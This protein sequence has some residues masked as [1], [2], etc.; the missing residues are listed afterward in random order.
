[1]KDFWKTTS[2]HRYL[3]SHLSMF[4]ELPEL[5]STRELSPK[6]PEINEVRPGKKEMQ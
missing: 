1:M 2:I 6:D 3:V 5:I 4:F